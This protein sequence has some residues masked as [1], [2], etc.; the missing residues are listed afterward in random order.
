MEDVTSDLDKNI[1]VIIISICF[2]VRWPGTP[3]GI[4]VWP[5]ILDALQFLPPIPNRFGVWPL[6]F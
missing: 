3:S 4:T 2:A 1:A 5:G 6:L